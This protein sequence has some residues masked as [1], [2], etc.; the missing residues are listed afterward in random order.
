[1]PLF[2][3]RNKSSTPDPAPKHSA[4]STT[5]PVSPSA[6]EGVGLLDKLRVRSHSRERDNGGGRG[7]AEQ[8]DAGGLTK[9]DSA[10][11]DGRPAATSSTATTDHS[12]AQSRPQSHARSDSKN[13]SSKGSTSSASETR[14]EDHRAGYGVKGTEAHDALSKEDVRALFSGAPHFTIEPGHRGRSFPQAFYPFALDLDLT[15]L[16]DHVSLTHE[17]F[18]LATLHSHLPVPVSHL[19]KQRLSP[20]SSATDSNLDTPVN[21][22][23][24]SPTSLAPHSSSAT[25]FQAHPTQDPVALEVASPS[26][27]LDETDLTFGNKF[28]PMFDLGIYERPNMLS[29][30]GIEPGTFGLH[31]FLERGVADGLTRTA[32]TSDSISDHMTSFAAAGMSAYTAAEAQYEDEKKPTNVFEYKSTTEALRALSVENARIGKHAKPYDRV[33]L[34]REGPHAWTKIGVRP[35]GMRTITERLQKAS[36]L[37]E[38]VVKKG[39]R[40]TALQAE[41]WGEKEMGRSLFEDLI[42]DQPE[43]H[44]SDNTASYDKGHSLKHQIEVLVKILTTPGA[45]LD[46]SLPRE[47]LLFAMGLRTRE[48]KEE[49]D[50]NGVKTSSK[51]WL[52]LVQLLLAV[53]LTIRLDAALRRGVA[54][55]SEEIAVSAMEIHRFNKLRNL[56]VDWDLAIAKRF[57][58]LCYAKPVMSSGFCFAHSTERGKRPTVGTK[59]SSFRLFGKFKG[60]DTKAEEEWKYDLAVLPRKPAIM[61]DG[62]VRFAEDIGWDPASI[63]H[64]QTD[65]ERKLCNVSKEAR[66]TILAHGVEPIAHPH[67]ARHTRDQSRLEVRAVGPDTLGG[68]LSHAWLGGLVIPGYSSCDILICALLEN[69][70]QQRAVERLG[71]I[72]YPRAGF[73]LGAK[74]WWSKICIVPCV[75]APA[76][77]SKERMGWIGLPEVLA[78]VNAETGQRM[79]D[80]WYL[81]ASKW[82]SRTMKKDVGRI[83]DVDDVARQSSTLGVGKGHVL[84]REFNMVTDR[85][86]DKSTAGRVPDVINLNLVLQ[87]KESDVQEN[88]EGK[89]LHQAS[90]I[91]DV[92]EGSSAAEGTAVTVHLPLKWTIRFVAQHPCRPP[93]GHVKAP[94]GATLQSD[95]P[96]TLKHKHAEHLPAHILH[97]SFKYALKCISDVLDISGDDETLLPDPTSKDDC[98]VWVVDA[99]GGWEK[100]VLVRAWCA[101]VGLHAIISRVG[102]GCIGCAV[103][104]ARALEVSVVIRVTR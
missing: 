76:L 66:E 36:E 100:E 80:G 70:T 18:A 58:R 71:N 31:A 43:S 61:I 75:L 69:D 5:S 82:G 17:S 93:H 81:V 54:M 77:G 59:A 16:H 87:E 92:K 84:G 94:I 2:H 72:A 63:E 74:S 96:T 41:G 9:T 45:W 83:H 57:Q 55:H 104:E 39:P 46:F 23:V 68:P 64:I 25:Y 95:S 40:F 67:L 30:H 103:R 101:Y 13:R 32:A 48:V 20:V 86:L 22:D 53:E 34:L 11:K 14:Q 37:R 60:Q 21:R 26:V 85:D 29:L 89:S 38:E 52:T 97:N 51:Q 73:V 56:K 99:R 8:A 28:R 91:A 1:M 7:A 42:F 44:P 19:A 27:A 102:R 4:S 15:D 98:E 33:G 50:E 6:S 49:T 12:T 79:T 90:V 3:H 35:I 62:L 78:P 10:S 88:A 24:Y 47:R 65:L